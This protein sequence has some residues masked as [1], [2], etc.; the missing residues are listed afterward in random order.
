MKHTLGRPKSGLIAALD[1]GSSKICCFVAVVEA[2]GQPRILGIGQQA[3][4]GVR[5]G[6]VIGMEVCE[7]AILNAVHGA[8]QMA[9]E[10]VGEVVVNLSGGHP[11]SSSVGVEVAI[12]GHE[13]GD[14]DLHRALHHGR[15]ANG[16]NGTNGANRTDSNGDQ[17]RQLIHSIPVG[18]TIDG[19]RGIRDPRGLFGER[20][21]V[22]MHLITAN[23]SA[24]R[25]LT[26]CIQRC[27]LDVS[28]FVVSPYASGLAA[29]VEDE[30]ELGVTVIDMGG[31][32]TSIAVFFEG[33]VIYT[34]LVAVGGIHV[35]HDIARGL[36][37]P[38][39]HAE[40]LKTLYG[41]AMAAAADEREMIDVPQVGEEAFE[42]ETQ[43]VPRSILVGI[44]QPRLE[45]TFELVRS[46][47]EA[48]GLDKVAGRRVVLTGGASQLPGLRDLAAL[49]LD[50]QVRIGRPGSTAGLAEATSGPA[51]ATCAG[52]LTCAVTNE[53]ATPRDK[54]P[55]E[56][57]PSNFMGR[58]G[59]W[60]REHF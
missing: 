40:R 2:N 37:A 19:N 18:Y 52:L 20:L 24:V 30:M 36:S 39:V 10:T 15:L 48:S 57:Q 60:V 12:D 26:T 17:S 28:G 23:A 33:S 14:S 46:R 58:L 4:R 13:V 47:L 59:D 38:L 43:Q 35:T 49:V 5:N 56:D 34:D 25:N 42:A 32:T 41:H 54:S 31:G 6:N 53:L 29:L 1:V 9:G 7:T 50:K 21:G 8:E 16:T 45:E 3:S 22:K 55:D 44:I 27:H 11:I 51:Y